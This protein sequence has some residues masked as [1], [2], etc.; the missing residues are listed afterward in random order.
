[1]CAVFSNKRK[2]KYSMLLL[3]DM[4]Q[5]EMN[6]TLEHI[7]N[8]SHYHSREK[9]IHQTILVRT[10]L[11]TNIRFPSAGVGPLIGMLVP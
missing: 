4:Y 3:R 10:L 8:E 7:T 2:M 1:M 9:L 5:L 11:V 6:L